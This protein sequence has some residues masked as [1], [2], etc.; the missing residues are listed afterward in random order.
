MRTRQLCPHGSAFGTTHGLTPPA[1]SSLAA[2]NVKPGQSPQPEALQQGEAR[3]ETPGPG[4]S[5]PAATGPGDAG[6]PGNPDNNAPQPSPTVPPV[7]GGSNRSAPDVTNGPSREGAD[8]ASGSGAASGSGSEL[9]ENG[10]DSAANGDSPTDGDGRNDENDR[11]AGLGEPEAANPGGG[12]CQS[13]TRQRAGPILLALDHSKSM[14]LPS[15]MDDRLATELEARMEENTPEGRQARDLYNGYIAQSGV[16]RLDILKES[17]NSTIRALPPSGT[18]GLVTF[19]GCEGV[20]DA[21]LFGENERD[22]LI[23]RVEALRP[24]PATPVAEALQAALGRARISG[25]GRVVL[26]TDGRDTCGGDPCAVARRSGGVRVDVLAMGGGR[27]LSCISD[28][29]GGRLIEA[30]DAT[31]IDQQIGELLSADYPSC[32]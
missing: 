20:V 9:Q 13:G 2:P 7:A 25:N 27:A 3:R 18:I 29:T 14:A 23:E 16:K 28:A 26:V 6:S 19:A 12:S 22:E 32:Q 24:V 1:S 21:G 5:T 4:L 15:Q 31:G 30:A 11:Q 17:V 10:Q 8:P